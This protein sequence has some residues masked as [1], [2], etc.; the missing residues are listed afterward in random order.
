M[1][2]R[3][4]QAKLDSN[5]NLLGFEDCV[6]DLATNEAR[7]GRPEDYLTKSVGYPYPRESKGC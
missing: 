5:V 7:A 1:Q 6:Y 2:D 3:N 4:F